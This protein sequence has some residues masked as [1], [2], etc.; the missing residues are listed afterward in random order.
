MKQILDTGKPVQSMQTGSL[1]SASTVL[2]TEDVPGLVLQALLGAGLGVERIDT[3]QLRERLEGGTGQIS[4]FW[5]IPSETVASA[6]RNEGQA[7]EIITDW[8]DRMRGLLSLMRRHRRELKLLDA[9]LVSPQAEPSDRER[10][11]SALGLASLPEVQLGGD[12]P[13]DTVSQ[14]LAV[15]TLS[16]LDMLRDCLDELEANSLTS[17]ND[18]LATSWLE[19][20]AQGL[21]RIRQ[22]SLDLKDKT[23]QDDRALAAAKADCARLSA[24]LAT[25]VSSA[26]AHA[27]EISLLRDELGVQLAEMS[28]CEKEISLLRDQL[29]VQLA[30]IARREEDGLR[31]E[32]L[33]DKAAY[34]SERALSRALTDLRREARERNSL[35]ARLQ[36][37]EARLASVEAERN[38]LSQQMTEIYESRSWRITKPLRQVRLLVAPIREA[39]PSSQADS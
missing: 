35:Q 9:R 20:A 31:K 37:T 23:E 25:T 24:E 8:L 6:L 28:R 17:G 3:E 27:Q 15:L 22:L 16:R 11:A 10:L 32:E 13:D 21:R 4:L 33:R 39:E 34:E 30:E 19:P 26:E 5:D 14:M 7:V 36:D 38:I 2:V 1:L 29:G 18:A 12:G